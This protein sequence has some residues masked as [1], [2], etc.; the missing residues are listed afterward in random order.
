M[1]GLFSAPAA[2]GSG[3][4]GGLADGLFYGG[5]FGSLVDQTLGVLV[6]IAWSGIITLVIALAIKF[7]LGWRIS[8]E[9]EVEGID[10]TEHGETGYDLVSRGGG[11]RPGASGPKTT[12]ATARNEGANA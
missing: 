5:G 12:D 4:V 2:E 6:A 8:E 7:T 1:I 10:Y 11:P 3:I 9:D